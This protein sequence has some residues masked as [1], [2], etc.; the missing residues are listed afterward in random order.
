MKRAVL[1][2]VLNSIARDH[3][4]ALTLLRQG[5]HEVWECGGY[6]FPIPRHREINEHTARGIINDLRRRLHDLQERS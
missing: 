6:R 4:V 3:D 2:S 1:L 5:K